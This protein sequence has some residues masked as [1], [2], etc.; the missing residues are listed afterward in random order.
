[1]AATWIAT[2]TASGVSDRGSGCGGLIV[3]AVVGFFVWKWVDG[4]GPWTGWVYPDASNLTVEVKLG[5]F[6]DFEQCQATAIAAL[7]SLGAAESG[8]YECGRQCK[9]RPE[10]GLN[11]CKETRN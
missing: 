1:M 11:V 2:T 7:R 4:R 10:L 5:E 3:L 6:P 8:D 9:F